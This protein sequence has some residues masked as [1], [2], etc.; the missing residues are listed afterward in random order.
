MVIFKS[1]DF[2]RAFAFFKNAYNICNRCFGNILKRIFGKERLMGS[3]D[4]IRHRDKSC[5][6]IILKNMTRI[7]LKEKLGLFLI[8]IKAGGADLA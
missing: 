7:I 1:T 8:N 4:N 2:I 5:E 6:R 3:D